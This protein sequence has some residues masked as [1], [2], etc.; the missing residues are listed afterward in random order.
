MSRP[1]ASTPSA[2]AKCSSCC[3]SCAA[4]AAWRSC[5]S[6]TT[7]W[8]PTTPTACYSLRDGRL[9]DHETEQTESDAH[10][11]DRR[12]ILDRR[13]MKP[14]N[15]LRLYRVRLRARG[16][17]SV[18]RSRGS[19]PGWRCC[20]PRRS[21]ARAC[22]APSV[23]LSRGIVGNAT[24]QLVAR[25]PHGFPQSMLARVRRHPRRARRGAAIGSERKRDRPER[26]RVGRADRRRSSLSELGGALVR[27]TAP[28]PF[29]GIGAVVLPAPSRSAGSA[30]RSSV[31]KSTLQLA[32]HTVAGAALRP[33][34]RTTDRAA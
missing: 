25:D 14:S 23:K 12:S 7:R 13:R 5:S 21:R 3:A 27:R 31:R 8:R 24:L 18:S 9:G 20:S 34:L 30:S 26:Q 28:T 22:R 29:G 19:P 1:G 11:S 16:C 32:G 17:R 10:D 6:A 4:S 2:V 33:A 15:A